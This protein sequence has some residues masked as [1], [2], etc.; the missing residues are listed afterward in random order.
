M[1]SDSRVG[2]KIWIFMWNFS[3]FSINNYFKYFSNAERPKTYAY[4]HT[5]TSVDH[6]SLT[7]K[8]YILQIMKNSLTNHHDK[9]P[10]ESIS[11]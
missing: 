11:W 7:S 9:L 3:N 1:I 10:E 8:E 2:M 4:T 6:N 5:H